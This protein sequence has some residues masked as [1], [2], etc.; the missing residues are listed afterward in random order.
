MS[1]TAAL[2]F[3]VGYDA[4]NRHIPIY[5][6]TLSASDTYL[7]LSVTFVVISADSHTGGKMVSKVDKS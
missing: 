6:A 2:E 4:E 1:L 5:F 7:T 3:K